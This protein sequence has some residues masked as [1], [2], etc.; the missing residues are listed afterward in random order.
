M[1][2]RYARTQFTDLNVDDM[3]LVCV[4]KMKLKTR[5]MRNLPLLTMN[6]MRKIIQI[7]LIKPTFLIPIIVYCCDNLNSFCQAEILL[8]WWFWRVYTII[9]HP[10]MKL[11]LLPRLWFACF[12]A[13]RKF[14]V[15]T[16]SASNKSIQLHQFQCNEIDIWSDPTVMECHYTLLLILSYLDQ[17][18]WIFH[19]LCSIIWW[20]IIWRIQWTSL[21]AKVQ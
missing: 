10:E 21:T 2:T 18:G 1:V 15:L 19:L 6:P 5:F 20:F 3:M 4:V 17:L 7:A 8:L 13:K 14:S 16:N 11:T 12:V 9:S